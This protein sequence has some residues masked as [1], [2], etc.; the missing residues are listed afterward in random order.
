MQLRHVLNTERW[1]WC[2]GWGGGAFGRSRHH[3][4]PRFQ[5]CFFGE[6][7][8]VPILGPTE[9]PKRG[10][11]NLFYSNTTGASI[12]LRFISRLDRGRLTRGDVLHLTALDGGR[13]WPRGWRSLVRQGPKP[14]DRP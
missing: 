8:R 10:T 3:N 1:R 9:E 12:R 11:S 6:R 4:A 14:M 13:A 2:V 7:A 5:P